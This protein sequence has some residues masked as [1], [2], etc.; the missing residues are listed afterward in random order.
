[1]E[2]FYVGQLVYSLA[3]LKLYRIDSITDENILRVYEEDDILDDEFSSSQINV[4]RLL[5]KVVARP[6]Y[7]KIPDLNQ[8]VEF[9]LTLLKDYGIISEGFEHYNPIEETSSVK[10]VHLI[11]RTDTTESVIKISMG[12]VIVSIYETASNKL[13]QTHNFNFPYHPEDFYKEE[14]FKPA[15]NYFKNIL[16][17]YGVD[18]L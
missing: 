3:D 15:L 14:F 12:Y 2:E 4:G 8:L 16:V 5:R 17:S 6:Y 11:K 1:M 18:E 7:G 13:L 9:V 10:T